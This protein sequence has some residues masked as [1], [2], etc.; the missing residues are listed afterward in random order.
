[1]TPLAEMPQPLQSE[2]QTPQT[3]ELSMSHKTC[4]FKWP[5]TA[6]TRTKP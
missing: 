5:Q 3:F 1:M 2:W 6:E 4:P